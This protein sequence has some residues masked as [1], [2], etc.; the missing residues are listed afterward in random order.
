MGGITKKKETKK[1]RKKERNRVR[2]AFLFL[3]FFSF[4][5]YVLI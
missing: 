1:E 2:D 3:V 5:F 4:S